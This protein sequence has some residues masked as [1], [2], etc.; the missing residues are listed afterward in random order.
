MSL[1]MDTMPSRPK[2]SKTT[3]HTQTESSRHKPTRQFRIPE[4]LAA[5]IDRV[6]EREYTTSP[7]QLIL[8]VKMYLAHKGEMP[9]PSPPPEQ[10]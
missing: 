10:P 8:A 2:P 4:H 1:T 5:M 6:A 7:T 3:Q 9:K